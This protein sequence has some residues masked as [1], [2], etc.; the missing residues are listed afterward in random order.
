MTTKFTIKHTFDPTKSTVDY[1]GELNREQLEVVQRGEGPVLVLA[2]AGSGKTRTIVYRVAYLLEKGI[3]A[4]NILLVTFTNKAAKEMLFRVERLL[5][6]Y[7]N[8]LWGGT[9]H[10]VANLLLR[11]HAAALGYRPNFTILDDEDSRD[12]ITVVVKSLNIDPKK[13]RFPSSAVLQDIISLARNTEMKLNGLIEERRPQFT[14]LIGT[15]EAIAREYTVRKRA[16]N[17]MDFDDLL[18]LLLDLLR[19]HPDVRTQL[20]SQFHYILVDEY[21]DTNRLQAE[22]VELLAADHHN[23]LV[24]GDDAQSIY[25]FRGADIGN[26]LEFPKRFAGTRVYKLETNYRSTQPIL[27]VANEVIEHNRKQYKKRLV[28]IR[29]GKQPPSLVPTASPK[30]EAEF[31]A[32]MMLQLRDEGIPLQKMAVLFRASHQSQA[33]EFELT[34]RDIPYEYRGGVRFFDRAHIKDVI[35]YLKIVS[36]PKDEVAWLRVLR[37][38]VGIGLQT[39]GAIYSQVKAASNLPHILASFE[40]AIPPRSLQGWRTLQQSFRALLREDFARQPSRLIE[41]LMAGEYRDY[42]M[43]EYPNAEDRLED[44]EQLALFAERYDA[45]D[46]FLAEVSLQEAFGNVEAGAA[47]KDDE[48]VVLST[49]HQAKGLEWDVVFLIHLVEPGF[50]NTKAL[51]E[52]NGLEEERRLFYVAVTR[53]MTHLFLCYPIA[54]DYRPGYGLMSTRLYESSRFLG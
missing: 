53:A 46:S 28:H 2:G 20:A 39:A 18:A 35:A 31:V 54:A 5:G 3:A 48:A 8:G 16:N 38:Q 41:L 44:L 30:Q 29:E 14:K 1:P 32:Q 43:N 23:L 40:P 50:P 11:K 26:I 22:I 10:H 52:E 19:N 13:E 24:V 7:P 33:L 25:S 4:E 37:L 6:Q 21:Q 12:L 17:Q 34:R 9:F 47:E 27:D 36:N 49:I 45:L 51:A 15:I 42:L